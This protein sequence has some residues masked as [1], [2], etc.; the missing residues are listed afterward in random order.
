MEE[1]KEQKQYTKPEVEIIE[2]VS[3]EVADT[4]MGPVD[5]WGNPYI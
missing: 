2:F 1:R 3:E 5:G 4:S